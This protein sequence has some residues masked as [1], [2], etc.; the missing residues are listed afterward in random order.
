[1]KRLIAQKQYDFNGMSDRE[2]DE[3]IWEIAKENLLRYY[4]EESFKENI[5]NANCNDDLAEIANNM[6]KFFISYES[7][8]EIA[9]YFKDLAGSFQDHLYEAMEE[10]GYIENGIFS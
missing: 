1:M 6:T 4:N 7:H 8:P 9:P 2:I 3:I 5:Q 10:D